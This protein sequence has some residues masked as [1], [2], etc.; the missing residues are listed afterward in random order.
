MLDREIPGSGFDKKTRVKIMDEALMLFAAKGYDSVSIRDLC[1]VVGI[2]ET[3][4]YY[5]FKKG[6]DELFEDVLRRFEN[7]Y[8]HYFEWLKSINLKAEALEELMDNMFNREMLEMADINGCFGMALI[9]KEQHN[10]SVRNLYFEL[11][12][13][14]SIDSMKE[15]FDRLVKKGVVPPSNTKM[16]ARGLM[17]SVLV[18]NDMRIHQYKGVAPSINCMDMYMELRNHITAS[19]KKGV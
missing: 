4:F 15:D 5:H 16:L 13:Q 19:L 14:F 7:G 12:H 9:V 18:I 3:T 6:K 8:R 11:F 1:R 17:H 10:E 2:K